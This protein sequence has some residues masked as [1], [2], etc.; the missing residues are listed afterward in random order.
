[1][2]A[3]NDLRYHQ[4]PLVVGRSAIDKPLAKRTESTSISLTT[5]AHGGRLH[6]G[7]CIEVSF[8]PMRIMLLVAL[9]LSL[10]VQ[11][12]A[13]ANNNFF[14]P[15]DAFFPTQLT[16]EDL[17]GLQA[18]DAADKV[19]RYSSFGGYSGAFCGYAGYGNAKFA[20]VDRAFIANLVT[21]YGQV[22]EYEQKELIEIVEKGKTRQEE[23]NGMRVLFYP[24]DF[25]IQKFRLG[26]QYNE[27]W[28]EE[29][30]KFGHRREH[31]RLCELIDDKNAVIESWRDA[32]LV[33]SFETVLPK[34]NLL[35][36]EPLKEPV[37]FKGAVKAI[38]LSHHSLKQYFNATEE[39]SYREIRVV[40]SS[41][42]QRYNWT[43]NAWQLEKDE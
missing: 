41:G 8:H 5:A 4:C 21:A 12:S 31:L 39:T 16:A 1:L 27:K 6:R 17:R 11:S 7:L 9:T 3:A 43:D 33:G 23:T 35:Q 40:D 13:K 18:G 20:T 38:V 42:V 25:D 15:G 26:L 28:V 24:R 32:T 30:I 29:A 37:L 22:R 10:H 36:G 19:F 34:A 2:I 14:L